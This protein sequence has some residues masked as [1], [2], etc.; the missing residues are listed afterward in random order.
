MP[1]QLPGYDLWKL[2]DRNCSYGKPPDDDDD[3]GDRAET[4]L[5]LLETCPN[6]HSCDDCSQQ[7]ACD[8]ICDNFRRDGD[9]ADEAHDEEGDQ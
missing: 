8:A 6:L 2:A 1:E 3:D 7:V 5:D 4:P 9:R